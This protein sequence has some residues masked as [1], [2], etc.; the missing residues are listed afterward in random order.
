MHMEWHLITP[1]YP[2][3]AGGV[4]DYTQV[5]ASALA[6]SGEAVHVWCAPATGDSSDIK[7]VTVHRDLGRFSIADLRRL[8][9]LLGQF[10]SPRRLLLKWVPHG[11]GYRSLNMGFCGWVW[12]RAVFAGDSVELMVHEPY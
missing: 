9:I 2:P 5:L 1:E 4:S 8:S 3:Q 11:D 12:Q 7:G 6:A 10:A